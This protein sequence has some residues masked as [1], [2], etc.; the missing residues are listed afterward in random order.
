MS[1]LNFLLPHD[2]VEPR[3][4]CTKFLIYLPLS[5]EDSEQGNRR[6]WL[7]QQYRPVEVELCDG[8]R[9]YLPLRIHKVVFALG[10]LWE[11]RTLICTKLR[12]TSENG[13]AT[14][15][16][17]CFVNGTKARNTWRIRYSNLRRRG[18]SGAQLVMCCWRA[19][20]SL[21]ILIF[22]LFL[23]NCNSCHCCIQISYQLSRRYVWPPGP[24]N[25]LCTR[26]EDN[27]L[28]T[29]LFIISENLSH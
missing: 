21:L 16:D 1:T 18:T 3:F 2:V 4:V 14:C 19:Y 7:G 9:S 28:L 22:F 27:E 8:G 20:A 10:W 11:L 26:Y 13:R 23:Q 12:P 24:S 5:R 29:H 25:Y 15:G 17:P 6:G